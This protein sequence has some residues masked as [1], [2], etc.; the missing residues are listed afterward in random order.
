MRL[1]IAFLA[2]SL[3]PL[4]VLSQ[5][6]SQPLPLTESEKRQILRQLYELESAREQIRAY[7][8]YVARDREQ[9]DRERQ[10]WQRAVELEKQAAALAVKERDLAEER[11]K[12]YEAAYKAVTAK[13]GFGCTLKKI[14]SF[15]LA[16]CR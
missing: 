14:F 8:D 5:T 12:F 15:G 9:D 1:W 10:N 11:A 6:S 4:S 7:Q 2:I 3:T 13:R 16:R